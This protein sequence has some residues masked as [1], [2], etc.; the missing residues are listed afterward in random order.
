M[1]NVS[2]EKWVIIRKGAD[3]EAI[4]KQ[5]HIS[6]FLARIIRNR[7]VIGDDNMHQ[8]LYGTMKDLHN[9]KE[10][11]DMEKAVSILLSKIHEGKKIRVIGDYDID[12]ICSTFILYSGLKRCGGDVDYEIPHRMKDGYGLNEELLQDAYEAG[13]DTVITCDNGIAAS[14]QIAYGKELGLTIVVTD[15]HEVPYKLMENGEKEYVIPPADAVVDSKQVDCLYPFKELCGAAVAWKFVQVLYEEIGIPVCEVEE[16][17]EFAAIATIGDVME[18]QGE[19]RILVKEGLKRIGHTKNTG[20]KALIE[21]KELNPQEINSY[22]IGFVIG[23]CMNASGRLDTA[24]RCLELFQCTDYAKAVSIATELSTLNEERKQLTNEGVE[25]AIRQVEETEIGKDKVLV[26]YLPECHESIAGIIAGR[27]RE[28]Y[29]KPVFVITNAEDGLKGSGRSI[30]GFSMFEEMC[31]CQELFTK[32]G[33][34]PL[35]AGLSLLPE[36][37][38]PFR[39]AINANTDLKEEDMVEKVGIDIDLPLEYVSENLINELSLLE[40]FGKG[41]E[42]PVFADKN[43]A[44]AQAKRIGKEKNMLKL[45]LVKESGTRMEA[46]YFKDADTLLEQMGEKYGEGAVMD[47]LDGKVNPVRIMAVYYPS[48]NEYLGRRTLQVVL[49]G[50]KLQ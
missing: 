24:K 37:L 47:M 20:L 5:F 39:K 25:E 43:M 49:Q 21:V 46:M 3:Y 42:K 14:S 4:G 41:N 36:N 29:Y 33:G 31:K 7:E 40:P 17:I 19:N 38:D 22:H 30:E 15:H 23:P 32:F 28:R 27:I 6:P 9:P 1:G 2:T 50:I 10:M 34:H 45:T 8:Y 11:K 26:V 35:A 48:V 13:V 16:L 44:I 18:L 12:G